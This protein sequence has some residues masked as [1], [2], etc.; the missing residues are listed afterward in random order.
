MT[1]TDDGDDEFFE[2]IAALTAAT[3]AAREAAP[4]QQEAA[5]DAQGEVADRLRDR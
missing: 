1:G 5:E 4:G 3:N 2:D